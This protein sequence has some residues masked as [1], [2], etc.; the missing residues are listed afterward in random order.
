LEGN[1]VYAARKR[2]VEEKSGFFPGNKAPNPS[3]A[4]QTVYLHARRAIPG[5]G[6]LCGPPAAVRAAD[7]VRPLCDGG[8]VCAD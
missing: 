1:L 5:P 8:L 7:G 6:G 2:V 4:V 3:R